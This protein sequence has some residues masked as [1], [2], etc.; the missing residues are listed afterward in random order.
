MTGTSVDA[1]DVAIARFEAKKRPK[2]DILALKEYPIPSNTR[3]RIFHIIDGRGNARDISHV[4]FALADIFA[5]AIAQAADCAGIVIR[6]IDAA[7]IHGQTIWHEPSGAPPNSLQIFS[8]PALAA[9]LRIPI[10]YDFRAADIALGGQGAPLSPAF[11]RDFLLRPERTTIVIN[12]GGIANITIL[13]AGGEVAAFD[14]GPGNCLIDALAMDHFKK[15]YD[16]NGEIA[17]SGNI[18]PE[19]FQILKNDEYL[20]IT[21]PKSTGRERYNRNF[22]SSAI[23]EANITDP[24]PADL[25]RTFTE[26]TAWSIAEAIRLYSPDRIYAA[27]GGLRNGFMTELLEGNLSIPVR[28]TAEAGLP[29][30]SR[31][32]LCFAWLAWLRM[33]GRPGNIPSVTGASREALLGAIAV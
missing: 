9:K 22:I 32:A 26:F 24:Q 21:P 13:P 7:G 8:G 25:I 20:N 18:I 30:D 14:T 19:L 12:I 11:D 17:G 10:V 5:R 33:A 23:A 2:M 3:D 31:E 28:S 29:P 6:Q 4:S 27:G 16:Q 1:L 15:K